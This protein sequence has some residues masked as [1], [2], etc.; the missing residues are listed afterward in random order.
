MGTNYPCRT[1]CLSPA[2]WIETQDL[3]FTAIRNR[4]LYSLS[5]QEPQKEIY[6]QYEDEVE[7]PAPSSKTVDAPTIVAYTAPHCCHTTVSAPS[8][9]PIVS[10]EDIPIKPI[11]ILLVIVA[12]KLKKGVDQIPLSKTI[13]DLVGGR[14]TLQNEIF[15][16]LQQEIASAPEKGEELSLEELGSALGSGST[17]FQQRGSAFTVVPF[18]Q[19]LKQDGEDIYKLCDCCV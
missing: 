8:S 15:G 12:Q 3:L 6:Y 17:V 16:N 13:K 18:N 5:C 9:G 14:S 19:A 11:D 2:R 10:I 4:S 7:A 1:T